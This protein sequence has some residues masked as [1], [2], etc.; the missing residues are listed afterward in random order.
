ME[1][2]FKIISKSGG[3]F[4]VKAAQCISI[5]DGFALLEKPND[6]FKS[7]NNVFVAV[8]NRDE[9]FGIFDTSHLVKQPN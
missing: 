5:K 8:F 6:P 3:T 9:V 1:K 2:T 7:D 4:E